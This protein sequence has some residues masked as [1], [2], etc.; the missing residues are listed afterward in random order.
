MI[1]TK[2]ISMV[3]TFEFDICIFCCCCQGLDFSTEC[4][5]FYFWVAIEDSSVT[6]N[7]NFLQKFEFSM[8]DLN[9]FLL[10]SFVYKKYS[11]N[12]TLHAT[13]NSTD[14][15]LLF[16]TKLLH[17]VTKWS[18][19]CQLTSFAAQKHV[20][21]FDCHTC[22]WRWL[23]AMLGLSCGLLNQSFLET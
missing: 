9:K 11:V 6:A 4:F 18:N 1:S 15:Q 16:G 21:L 14:S 22:T 10:S 5:A 2:Q 19:M 8:K 13:L 12:K 20:L 23:T 3:L 17:D 7:C